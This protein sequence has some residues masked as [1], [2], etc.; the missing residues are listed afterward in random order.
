MSAILF[1]NGNTVSVGT[2][3]CIARNYVAHI[4][5][6]HNQQPDM[7]VI[8]CKPITALNTTSEIHLPQYSQNI[9]Y[10]TELVVQI[11]QGGRNIS[12]Q[13]ALSHIGGIGLGLDLTARDIQAKLQANSWPWELAKGF[14][15]AACVSEFVSADVIADWSYLNFSL[16]IN[17]ELRQEGDS[18]LM[19][20]S[21]AQQIAFISRHFGLRA[22]DL[23]F[24]GTPAGVDALSSGD[25]LYAELEHGLITMN[26]KVY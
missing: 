8:F 5:E 2:I 13:T 19:I 4:E 10:E 14:E 1:Q 15:G 17:D 21:I 22:G 16:H 3:F 24:T 20:F 9:H 6:L 23:L 7:P 18:R 12:E 26:W 25:C 11:H